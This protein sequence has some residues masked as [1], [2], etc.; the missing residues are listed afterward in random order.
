MA[1]AGVDILPM[2][3][4]NT[5]TCSAFCCLKYHLDK[6]KHGK[7]LN[8]SIRNFFILENDPDFEKIKRI[9]IEC[10]SNKN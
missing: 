7:N 1:A 9:L 4:P 10:Y 6:Q 2:T 8:F 5:W 3:L